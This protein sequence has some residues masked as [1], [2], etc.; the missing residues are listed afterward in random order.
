MARKELHYFG[1]DLGYNAPPR[2][3]D[4][5]HSY[6][7]HAPEN[8]LVG[9]TSTWLLTS[10]TAAAEIADYC[11]NAKILIA[12]REPV[13]WLHSLHSHHL[14]TG[15]ENIIDI[16]TAVKNSV[17]RD[18]EKTRNCTPTGALNYLQHVK[19]S[20]GVQRFI[21]TFGR[22]NVCVIFLDD[23]KHDPVNTYNQIFQ[24]LNVEEC[25]AEILSEYTPEKRTKNANRGVHSALIQRLI[26]T[27]QCQRAY[28]G[29]VPDPLGL[30]LV[31]RI[32]KRL[33]T[34]YY[35]RPPTQASFKGWLKGHLQNE[36]ETLSDLLGRDLSAWRE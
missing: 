23:L 30:G 18:D 10:K 5:Y 33:N 3:R 19:Y 27:Q 14:Y 11:P 12:L 6:F 21:N 26:R 29:L 7:N 9:E 28:K 34:T 4:D 1:Q 15:D 22:D 20:V 35:H 8:T 2:S 31:V 25:A 36:L 24:F 13:S 32:L 16:E 17:A